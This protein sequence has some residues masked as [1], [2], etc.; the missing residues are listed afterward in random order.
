M[1]AKYAPGYIYWNLQD[2][3]SWKEL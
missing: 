2:Q 3:Y 1:L